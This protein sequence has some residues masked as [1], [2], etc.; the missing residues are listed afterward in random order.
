VYL[1]QP[2]FNSVIETDLRLAVNE[3]LDR[4]VLDSFASP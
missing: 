4:L 1:E 2:A 3:G